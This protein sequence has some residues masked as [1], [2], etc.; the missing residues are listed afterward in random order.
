V[1]LRSQ[2]DKLTTVILGPQVRNFAQIKPGDR[3]VTTVTE[4][5]A[6]S[7]AR[8]DGAAPTGSATV[9]GRAAEGQRPGAGVAD[10]ERMR[11]R[12]EGIDLG[13]NSVTFTTPSG[14]RREVRVRDERM[15]RFVRT[16]S[17]GDMVDVVVIETVSVRVLPAN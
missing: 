12:I 6:A 8:P 3:V 11:V 4:A 13:R 15:R 9:A 10:A 14:T 7:F 2:D 16:L 17:P 1:L 5:V